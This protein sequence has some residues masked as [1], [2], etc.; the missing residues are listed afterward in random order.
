[1]R[2]ISNPHY[3]S[4]SATLEEAA[5][6][7]RVFC[8]APEHVFWPETLSLSDAGLFDLSKLRGH[9]QITDLY[10]AGLA[11][12]H[13]GRLATLDANIPVSALVG[14]PPNVIEL[15]PPN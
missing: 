13:G 10:L 3:T 4:V 15:V 11:H 8:A 12:H 2:V 9:Q 1:M 5:L 6:R 7:L 14:A